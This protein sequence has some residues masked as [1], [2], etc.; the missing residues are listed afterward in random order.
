MLPVTERP[1]AFSARV[2]PILNTMLST[3]S[4]PTLIVAL[5]PI[6]KTFRESVE[7]FI[8]IATI[9]FLSALITKSLT[10]LNTF[11]CGLS[12]AAGL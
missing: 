11:I 5:A 1:D 8:V 10:A 7:A 9:M 4:S 3:A 2:F 6:P 12:A